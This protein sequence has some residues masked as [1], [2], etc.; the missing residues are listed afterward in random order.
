M[1]SYKYLY[2]PNIKDDSQSFCSHKLTFM[3]IENGY[4]IPSI[5]NKFGGVL[6]NNGEYIKASS[7]HN[8]FSNGYEVNLNNHIYKEETVIYLGL[9]ENCWGHWL[10][11]NIK[12]IWFFKSD[13]YKKL[14]SNC[15]IVYVKLEYPFEPFNISN[16]VKQ[17]YNLLDFDIT[18]AEEI[19]CIT[20]YKHIIIPDEC[21]FAVDGSKRFYT[22]EYISMINEI[23]NNFNKIKDTNNF[24]SCSYD[25]IYFSYKKAGKKKAVGEQKLEKFFYK[26]GYKIIYPEKYSFYEQLYMLSKAN[27]L[28]STIGSCSHNF[29]FTKDNANIILIPR[30]NYLTGYQVAINNLISNRTNIYYL[31]SSLSIYTDYINPWNGPFYYYISDNLYDYFKLP[32]KNNKTKDFWIYSLLGCLRNKRSIKAHTYK[33][34]YGE[35]NKLGFHYNTF[36]KPNWTLYSCAQKILSYYNRI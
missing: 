11:D 7:L 29:L 15:K 22:N 24:P 32:H 19:D 6:N 3:D 26:Q 12:R 21:F 27:Y 4:I 35:F 36:I 13:F 8:G 23:K 18:K 5:G 2:N 31:D 17:L 16:N 9:L 20:K 33:Y 34:Y 1:I 25:K 14:F 28:A 10:T 30:A